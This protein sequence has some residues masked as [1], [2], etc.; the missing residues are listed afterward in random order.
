[1][2][3]FQEQ[4]NGMMRNSFSSRIEASHYES[5]RRSFSVQ[6]PSIPIGLFRS[7]SHN[8]SNINIQG[9]DTTSNIPRTTYQ[10]ELEDDQKSIQSPIYSSINEPYEIPLENTFTLKKIN[11][12]ENGFFDTLREKRDDKSKTNFIIKINILFFDWFHAYTIIKDIE[13]PW[14]IDIIGDS[15]TNVIIT[16]QINDSELIQSELP[17]TIQYQLSKVKDSNDKSVMATPFKTKDVNEDI[18]SKDIKSLMEQDN[19]TNKYLEVSEKAKQKFKELRKQKLAK[20]EEGDNNS[21]LLTK[22]NSLLKTIPETPQTSE[23]S[24]KI[25]T[26]QT[27]KLINTIDKD[28]ET[29]YQ[30]YEN[31]SVSE[32]EINPINK[33]NWKTPSKLYYQRLAAPDL[34]LEERGENNFRIFSAK[35][36]YKWNKDAQTKYNILNTLQHMSMVVTA[37][38]TTQIVQKKQYR[39]FW[40]IERMIDLDGKVIINDDKEEILDVV[41]TLIFTIAQQFIGD[42]SLWKNRSAE[43]LSN[44]RCRTLGDF[45]S[46][47]DTFL[48][49]VYT[50]EDCHQ[51]FWKEKFLAGLPKSL[52]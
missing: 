16:W 47:K 21:E 27:S 43:L 10:Q 48:A 37:Y 23:D 3:L 26:R 7:T 5:T 52:G 11:L 18:T 46:Y 14:Q 8:Q 20:E 29:S 12:R 24:H 45:R 22:N 1:M 17:P 34:L 42:P 41:N 4:L 6:T 39:I 33:K 51:P 44:L 36:I 31:G 38:Q 13:Y 25:R 35:N 9:L 2:F 28:N 19:Y 30:A 50:R 15:F 40:T 32:K 49:R